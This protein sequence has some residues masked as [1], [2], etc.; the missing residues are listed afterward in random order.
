[1]RREELYEIEKEESRGS[2]QMKY[3]KK[4]RTKERRP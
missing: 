4:E 2:I 3:E 1:M